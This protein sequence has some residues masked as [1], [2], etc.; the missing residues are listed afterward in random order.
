MSVGV[1][2]CA[3]GNEATKA[4]K[5]SEGDAEKFFHCDSPFGIRFYL[6]I[7]LSVFL[8]RKPNASCII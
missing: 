4:K 3:A 2:I 7:R 5:K 6:A 1:I 8:A